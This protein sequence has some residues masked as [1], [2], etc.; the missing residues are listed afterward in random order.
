MSDD[1]KQQLRKQGLVTLT[2]LF[3]NAQTC[4]DFAQFANLVQLADVSR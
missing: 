4:E 1:L 2:I 3:D